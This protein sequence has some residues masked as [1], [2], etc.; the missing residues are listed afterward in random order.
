MQLFPR[1]TLVPCFQF[2][3]RYAEVT[4]MSQR[5]FTDY[6]LSKQK[7][8]VGLA[9]FLVKSTSTIDLWYRASKT[10][11]FCYLKAKQRLCE[12]TF[13]NADVQCSKVS[14]ECFPF[15]LIQTMASLSRGHQQKPPGRLE[16]KQRA[17]AWVSTSELKAFFASFFSILWTPHN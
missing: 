8:R 14:C 10:Q 7:H 13:Q 1:N 3:G 4:G 9:L 17:D 6:A 16:R 15:S 5:C 12:C 11:V 2:K